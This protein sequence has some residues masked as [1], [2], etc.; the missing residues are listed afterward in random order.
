MAENFID[1]DDAPEWADADFE[2][3]EIRAGGKVVRPMAGEV[4]WAPGWKCRAV[5][6]ALGSFHVYERIEGNVRRVVDARLVQESVMAPDV[7]L[8]REWRLATE[9][10]ASDA[11]FEACAEAA[12]DAP[13]AQSDMELHHVVARDVIQAIIDR[14][15][16]PA[17]VV[18]LTRILRDGGVE[19]PEVTFD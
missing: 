8:E 6:G 9:A 16:S 10:L 7:Y 19:V 2:R 4:S 5:E 1:A 12:Y 3:A 11:I 14:T 13:H 18:E 15:P 17:T